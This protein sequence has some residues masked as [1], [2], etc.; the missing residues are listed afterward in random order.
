MSG[1]AERKHAKLSA[2]GSHRWMACPGSVTLEELF[3]DNSTSYADE[4]TAA[5]E[6][7][8]LV[9][10][11]Q[12]GEIT[13]R[14]YSA[15]LKKHEEGE[16]YSPAMLEY[17]QTYVDIVLER[18][19][20]AQVRT[21]DAQILLEQ[22]LD[23]SDWVPDGFGT[24]DVVI[25]SDG[26]LEV[27]DLKYGKGVQVDAENNSQLRLYGLG[28]WSE[29]GFLYDFET[30]R[31]TIVQPR[32]D[33]VS[34][35]ELPLAD[36]LA[37]GEDKVKPATKKVFL[38]RPPHAAG[39]WCKFCRAKSHCRTRARANLELAK[40]EFEEP[41]LLSPEEI[42]EILHKA[43]ELKAWAED[44]SKYALN[45]AE[46]H[47]VRF[48][49]WKLVEGRSN[50]TITDKEKAR[51]VLLDA[52]YK[53]DQI[54]KPQELRGIT[55]LESLI[56]KKTFTSLM[57]DLIT[58]PPGKPKLAPVSDPRPEISSAASAAEDF[59]DG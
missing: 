23:F 57:G 36:L 45:Q 34:T 25:I 26:I 16:Y 50:R 44:I 47:G 6:L 38:P 53:E 32:L 52:K 21:K 11:L 30:I 41:A 22:R 1:H 59:A 33:H 58:K 37:W 17:V 51:M 48:P 31:M 35:E 43:D 3:P 46:N 42:G 9:L 39:D 28:A 15:E 5:H 49:G 18:F 2:S 8:E 13:K 19:A 4:G 24:G 7:S 29:H 55:D 54:L 10:K 12:L 14:K 56:G 20:E 40:H 27:I